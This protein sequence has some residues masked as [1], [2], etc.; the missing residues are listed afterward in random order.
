MYNKNYWEHYWGQLSVE[1]NKKISKEELETFDKEY[2]MY[3]LAGKTYGQ[4]F[5]EKFD[6]RGVIYFMKDKKIIERWIRDNY[7]I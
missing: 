7:I 4:A 3:A 1:E 2:I 5:C 6:I